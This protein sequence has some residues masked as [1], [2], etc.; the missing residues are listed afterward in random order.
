MARDVTEWQAAVLTSEE[1]M[2]TVEWNV[3]T[4]DKDPRWIQDG[5]EWSVT[6]GGSEAQ[7]FGSI[8]PR[9]HAFVPTGTIL[10]I[11]P[12]YG[13]WTQYLKGNC[14]HLIVVDQAEKCIKACQ[15]RFAADANITYH[16]NDG[17]SSAMILDKSIDFVFSFDSLVHAEADVIEG[18]LDQ[19][20]LK[21]NP[22]GVGFV[23]HSNLGVYQQAA[24]II[25][26]IPNEFRE[27]VLNRTYL[28]STQFR[29]ASVTAEL[30]QAYCRKANL[31]CISQET[32]NWGTEGLL[33]DCFAVFTPSASVW[34][35]PTKV[36]NNTEFMKEASLIRRLLRQ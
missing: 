34:S 3:E 25:R 4:W 11:V 9:I 24:A 15:R 1:R 30:F 32:V 2:P 5:E 36:L 21:L 19:L 33:I 23:H 12:G 28:S 13:R 10:E 22:N 27:V 18:Y 35:H 6:W 29:A 14:D 7:W 20:A 26:Q 8:L 16:V 17:R 31:Q